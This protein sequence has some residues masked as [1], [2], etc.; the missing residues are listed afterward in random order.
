M[1]LTDMEE[2]GNRFAKHCRPSGQ[3]WQ[4]VVIHLRLLGN[5]L[6]RKERSWQC[7]CVVLG[8]SCVEF[9]DILI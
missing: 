2:F 6:N 5:Y 9:L 8:E 4:A 1:V 7:T 3:P